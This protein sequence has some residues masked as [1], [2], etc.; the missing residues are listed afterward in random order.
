M[1]RHALL[2]AG[3]QPSGTRAP[4]AGLPRRGRAARAAE[5][6]GGA[7]GFRVGGLLRLSGDTKTRS[8]LVIV[9]LKLIKF[10]KY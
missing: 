4:A 6:P 5:L 8:I 1:I 9:F 3:D 7:Q 10:I 2:R